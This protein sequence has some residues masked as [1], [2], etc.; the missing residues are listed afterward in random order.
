MPVYVEFP[1]ETPFKPGQYRAKIT[2]IEDRETQFGPALWLSLVV[3]APGQYQGRVLSRMVKKNLGSASALGIIYRRLCGERT[4]RTQVD[5]EADLVG[6]ECDVWVKP[7]QK[8][9]RTFNR[10]DDIFPAQDG[11]AS[12]KN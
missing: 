12:E 1:D 3:T 7:E 2:A 6:R 8:D 9:G 5:L 10:I 11:E 4:A